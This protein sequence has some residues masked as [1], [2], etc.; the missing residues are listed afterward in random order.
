[1]HLEGRELWTLSDGAISQ[2]WDDR[3]ALMLASPAAARPAL[4]NREGG[5]WDS[6]GAGKGSWPAVVY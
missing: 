4:A 2:R 5:C 3:V 6:S 1:M